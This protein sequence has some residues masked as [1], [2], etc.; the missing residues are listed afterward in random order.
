MEFR[1]N[2]LKM[3]AKKMAAIVS[4]PCRI[5]ISALFYRDDSRLN[6]ND[7]LSIV[8]IAKNEEKYLREWVEFHKYVG[9][10][11]IYLFDNNEDSTVVRQLLSDYIDVGYVVYRHLPGKGQQYFAYE[12][13]IAHFREN[14]RYMAFIDIDEYLMSSVPGISLADQVKAVFESGGKNAAGIAVNWR[15]YGSSGFNDPPED[16]CVVANY[17]FRAGEGG[18]GNGVIKTIA[19]P[20]KIWRYRDAHYP[21]YFF[22]FYAINDR[23]LRCDGAFNRTESAGMRL[24]INHYFTKSK[25]EWLER[26]SRPVADRVNL[27]GRSE[28][29]LQKDFEKYDQNDTFDPIARDL[30]NAAR[31]SDMRK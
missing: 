12:Y 16:Y 10:D 1:H 8:A 29:E 7:F 18:I 24:R 26:R 11:R 14:T 28:V 4:L 3:L 19:N 13:A 17:L 21:I 9:I 5:L 31:E 2:S 25:A 30:F 20:R 6:I 22:P 27:R 23:G 15:M